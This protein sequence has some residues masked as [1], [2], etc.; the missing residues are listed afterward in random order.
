MRRTIICDAHTTYI[1]PLKIK[2]SKL[3]INSIMGNYLIYKKLFR[4]KIMPAHL[5]IVFEM[6]KRQFQNLS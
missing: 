4:I 2:K 5:F 3:F 6:F 1:Y